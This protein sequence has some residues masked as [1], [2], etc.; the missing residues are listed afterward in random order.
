M[1]FSANIPEFAVKGPVHMLTVNL[2]NIFL[3]QPAED[4]IE[5]IERIGQKMAGIVYVAV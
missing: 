1:T 2:P 5:V 4:K 3:N